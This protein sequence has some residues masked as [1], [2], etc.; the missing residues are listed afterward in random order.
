MKDDVWFCIM[1]HSCWFYQID[2]FGGQNHE[3]NWNCITYRQ[4]EV[5]CRAE[6]LTSFDNFESFKLPL[7]L[8]SFSGEEC[9]RNH[10]ICGGICFS[11]NPHLIGAFFRFEEV[12]R[13]LSSGTAGKQMLVPHNLWSLHQWWWKHVLA[14]V[15]HR[16][17]PTKQHFKPT[18]Q[19]F[20]WSHLILQTKQR[21][22]HHVRALRI[23]IPWFL[24]FLV[25]GY[26]PKL[27]C[28]QHLRNWAAWSEWNPVDGQAY[29]ET[30][31]PMSIGVKMLFERYVMWLT[32]K[33]M[34]LSS[35]I[36]WNTLEFPPLTTLWNYFYPSERVILW[37]YG[38][39]SASLCAIDLHLPQLQLR[40]SL[41]FFASLLFICWSRNWEVQ[42]A[43]QDSIWYCTFPG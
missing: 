18:M 21:L 19:L 7:F 35:Q 30:W 20:S 8:G 23:I 39:R 24:F 26:A 32:I 4:I 27:L 40:Q 6:N 3:T 10:I 25:S 17:Q 38:K 41:V 31:W 29:Q 9:W 12:G 36:P 42:N 13:L 37:F 34:I 43:K 33:N 11:G 14:R 28:A 5:L 15:L 16:C 22:F 2:M 1:N